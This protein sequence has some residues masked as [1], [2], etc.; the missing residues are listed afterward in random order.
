M[1]TIG[2]AIATIAC[3]G[4]TSTS[5]T[6]A[7]PSP[8]PPPPSVTSIALSPQNSAVTVGKTLQLT[9][10]ATFSDGTSKNI[11][12]SSSTNWISS[13]KTVATVNGGLVTGLK[14][15]VVT[16]S[17][18]SGSV[19]ASTLLNVTIKSFSNA[20]LTGAYAFTLTGTGAMQKLRLEVGSLTATGNGKISGVED[21][22]TSS[23]VTSNVSLSGTYSITP[24]GRGTL[25]LTSGK[26]SRTFHLV[27]SSNSSSPN[28][29][30]GK[31]IEF[32]TKLTAIGTLEK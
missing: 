8:P 17:V 14:L 10:T 30:N 20:S 22:N 13:D 11:S 16:V 7:K 27:L 21:I 18:A 1:L 25:T 24:D 29:N 28:D 15:G 23:G 31:L 32:D 9:A 2:V 26:S 3:G 5:N 19:N 6:P 12:S 4:G